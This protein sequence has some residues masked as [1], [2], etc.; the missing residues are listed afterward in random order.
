MCCVCAEFLKRWIDAGRNQQYFVSKGAE[1][2]EQ[3]A[4]LHIPV[5]AKTCYTAKF[6]ALQVTWSYKTS[7]NLDVSVC[8]CGGG[9]FRHCSAGP[10]PGLFGRSKG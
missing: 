10:L 5:I 9:G 4:S 2:L 7:K 8:V 1:W 6:H 3:E